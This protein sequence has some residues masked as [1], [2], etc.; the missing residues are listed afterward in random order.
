MWNQHAANLQTALLPTIRACI[1]CND[2][3]I[4]RAPHVSRLQS[5]SRSNQDHPWLT[6]SQRSITP[7][8]ISMYTNPSSFCGCKNSACYSKQ[9]KLRYPQNSVFFSIFLNLNPSSSHLCSL[10]P[11]LRCLAHTQWLFV[12]CSHTARKT[13]FWQQKFRQS[14]IRVKGSPVVLP[15]LFPTRSGVINFRVSPFK[16]WFTD[17]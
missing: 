4:L 10:S 17:G 5:A 6:S 14:T 3:M 11:R 9:L 1:L 15:G 7:F 8:T 13:L 2:T 12:F 16:I